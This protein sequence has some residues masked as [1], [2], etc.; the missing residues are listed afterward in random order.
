MQLN[1]TIQLKVTLKGVKMLD[2]FIILGQVP[3][4]HYDL[5]FNQIVFGVTTSS[6]IYWAATHRRFLSRKWLHLRLWSY[7]ARI[8]LQQRHLA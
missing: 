7:V 2:F 4:T 1:S 8:R 3:F 6:L 5:S